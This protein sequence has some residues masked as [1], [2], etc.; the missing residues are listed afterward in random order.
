LVSNDLGQHWQQVIAPTQAMLTAVTFVN[1]QIGYAVGHQ[2]VILKTTDGGE[3]WQLQYHQPEDLSYPAL[4]DVWFRDGGWGLAIGAYGLMLKTK[5][6]GKSWEQA[7]LV[8]LEDP[9]FGLPH[10]YS[11]AFDG[12]NNRLYLAGELGFVAVSDDFGETW[13]RLEFPYHGSLFHIAISANGSVHAMGLRGHL[14]R[15]ED[16]GETWEQVET[17]V[18]ASINSMVNLG[19][20]QLAYFAVDGVM[21]FSND[22]GKT[23]SVSQLTERS[24]LMAAVVTGVNQLVV[25]GEKGIKHIDFDGREIKQ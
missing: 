13:E 15:S 1:D 19:G 5:D 2:Q 10:F 14:F 22:D 4:F 20:S 6:G 12:K 7:D 11:L 21:L 17:G 16:Q 18:L 24:G 25:V 9:D 3:S 23:V 8:E